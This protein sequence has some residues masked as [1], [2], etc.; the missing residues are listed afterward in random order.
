VVLGLDL[1]EVVH[2][3]LPLLHVSAPGL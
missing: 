1:L 3:L 2:V